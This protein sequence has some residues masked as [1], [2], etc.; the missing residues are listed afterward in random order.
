MNKGFLRQSA[1]LRGGYLYV[2][3]RGEGEIGIQQC[4]CEVKSAFAVHVI[5]AIIHRPLRWAKTAGMEGPTT[6]CPADDGPRLSS[7]CDTRTRDW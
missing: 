3:S 5:V 2:T 4:R 7:S 6:V 1:S